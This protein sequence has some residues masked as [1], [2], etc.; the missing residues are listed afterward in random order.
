[1]GP[2]SSEAVIRT[3]LMDGSS[4]PVAEDR[5]SSSAKKSRNVSILSYEILI[6]WDN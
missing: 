3:F 1:M 5:L 2:K 4:S 6:N